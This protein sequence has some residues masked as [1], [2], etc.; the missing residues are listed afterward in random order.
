MYLSCRLRLKSNCIRTSYYAR[1]RFQKAGEE[2]GLA[3]CYRS[4]LIVGEGETA[5]VLR[6]SIGGLSMTWELGWLLQSQKAHPGAA[7]LCTISL[8]D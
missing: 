6:L 1:S 5:E 7:R 4:N 2:T 8:T 3:V